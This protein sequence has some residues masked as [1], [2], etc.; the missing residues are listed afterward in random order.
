M[1]ERLATL[2]AQAIAGSKIVE[3]DAF[4]VGSTDKN[5]FQSYSLLERHIRHHNGWR[6]KLQGAELAFA[7]L[8]GYP[9]YGCAKSVATSLLREL[10]ESLKRE[11]VGGIPSV[12]EEIQLRRWWRR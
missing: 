8:H 9:A 3:E 12:P 5:A 2:L 11:G 4:F 10:L 7:D 1:L 6:G